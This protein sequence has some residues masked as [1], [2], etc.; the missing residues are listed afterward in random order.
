MMREAGVP[1]RGIDLDRGIGRHLPDKGLEAEKADLFDYLAALPEGALDGIFCAQVVEH[2]PP[3]RLPEMVRLC[4]SRLSRN[5]V[6]RDRD[7]QSGVPRHLR[8]AL[9]SRPDA[10]PPG[11]ASAAGVLPGRVRGGQHRSHESWRRR[12][13]PMPALA[14]LPEGFPGGLLRGLRLR[15]SA[16]ASCIGATRPNTRAVTEW[17]ALAWRARTGA[18][19]GFHRDR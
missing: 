19:G 11:S 4:A 16:G 7:A 15:D 14:S 17:R 8:H 10:H 1:A 9:L 12:W 2:L 6:D 18:G 5:G 13:N 3:E